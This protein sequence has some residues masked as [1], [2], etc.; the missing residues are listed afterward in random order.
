MRS[1]GARQKSVEIF[2]ACFAF[3]S[4]SSHFL[5]NKLYHYQLGTWRMHEY[6]ARHKIALRETRQCVPGIGNKYKI[7]QNREPSR[8]ETFANVNS[9]QLLLVWG[10]R[11]IEN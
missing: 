6:V 5:G 8:N 3:P 9:V 2:L 1:Q 10:I 7:K 11:D 4:Y